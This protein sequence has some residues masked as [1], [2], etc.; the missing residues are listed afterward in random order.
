MAAL[1]TPWDRDRG[2]IDP[3]GL[4]RLVSGGADGMSP[5]GSTGEGA[6][7]TPDQRVELPPA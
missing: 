5:A 1:V 6:L 3:G 2:G 7:L 4:E